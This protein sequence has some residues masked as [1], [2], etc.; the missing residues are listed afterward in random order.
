MTSEAETQHLRQRVDE[1]EAYLASIR[2][3]SIDAV[4]GRDGSL[5]HIA[6][7]WHLNAFF[8]AMNEG[9]V[10][11]SE[12]QRIQDCNPAFGRM[13]GLTQEQTRGMVFA[14][15]M[16]PEEI[17]KLND[18]LAART[19]PRVVV[20][21]LGA[22]TQPVPVRIAASRLPAGAGELHCLFITDMREETAARE[23]LAASELRYRV[24][25]DHSLEWEYWLGADGRC[26]Y[27]SPACEAI[28]GYPPEAFMADAGLV[29]RLVHPDDRP[30][31][32]SHIRELSDGSQ[33]NTHFA[34]EFRLIDKA[35]SEHWVE[36][37]CA[38]IF[39]SDGHC[40]GQRG[41][42]RDI[43]QRKRAELALRESQQQYEALVNRIPDG[44]FVFAFKSDGGMA[45]PYVSPRFC[46]LLG[47]DGP[48]L[49]A[50]AELA[51]AAAHPDD[52]PG[53]RRANE[54]A[55]TTLRPF[56]WEGRFV[57][58]GE[59]RWL[60]VA[61]EA[62]PQPDGG[63]VWN[64]VMSDITESKRAEIQL[65]KLAQAV[66]QSPESVVITDLHAHIEYVN[67]AFLLA[68]GYSREEVYGQN[69]RILH[70][71]KTPPE[72][73]TQMWDTLTGGRPW[74][75]EFVNQRRDGSE[76]TE[77]AIIT[78]VRQPDGKVTHYVAVKEDITEKKRTAEELDQ[79]RHHLE[80]L[81]TERTE[82]LEQ[83]V[84]Q[85]QA[86]TKA[87]AAFL[88]NMSHEIR[89]PMNAILGMTHLLKRGDITPKQAQQLQQVERSSRHLLGLINDI[90]DL[91]KVE[92]GR[93]V[94][95]RL[96]TRV[97]T[98]PAHVQSMLREAADAKGIRIVVETAPLPDGLLGDPTRLTQALLNY[99]SNAV[100]FTQQGR[101]V[102]RTLLVEDNDDN[103]LLRFEVEDS[104]VGVAPEALGRLF[105][106]FEQADNS[107]T[108]RYGGTGL[109][110]AI[111]RR[112]AELMG[113]EW[114]V[115]SVPGEGSTFWFTARL[116]KGETGKGVPDS[117]VSSADAEK[118]IRR[119]RRGARLLLVEDEPVNREVASV[120]LRSVGLVVE[121]AE[122][123]VAALQRLSEGKPFDAVLM[124]MQ[125]PVM[126]GLDATRAVREL[127][128]GSAVPILAM[129]AN[130][131]AEDRE[132][133]L[134]AG[135][136]DF[137]AKPVDPPALFA[138]LLRWLPPRDIFPGVVGDDMAGPTAGAA[139]DKEATAPASLRAIMGPGIDRAQATLR[140]PEQYRR[141]VK[142]FADRQD[143]II[144]QLREALA[145]GDPARA[146]EIT[147]RLKG[148]AGNLGL[149]V[150]F[151][152]AMALNTRLRQDDRAAI[153]PG[154]A[155]LIEASKA[156]RETTSDWHPQSTGAATDDQDPE[157]V[158]AQLN[159]WLASSDARAV[160]YFDTHQAL[161]AR[162]LNADLANLAQQ[163]REFNFS[164]AQSDLQTLQTG[165]RS[166]G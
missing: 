36:H 143:A 29:T 121:E 27:A 66:E 59:T 126:D 25:A 124:D 80:T 157:T 166:S 10:T 33:Q 54:E 40:L 67:E 151:Q 38:P 42:N 127:P 37:V 112:L 50:D 20:R 71:G 83:A 128:D 32:S 21:L 96:P 145:F 74:K 22:D 114:G 41:A 163:I 106:A 30:R 8:Q 56:R 12:D 86:A 78:P 94:L 142:E 101:I 130:A 152:A 95:E 105:S 103:A 102:M 9:A 17:A 154:L 153:E 69:P 98:I 73:Y 88:A 18:L 3:G 97:A 107:T 144:D 65:R 160:E 120:L 162:Y 31:F 5:L 4:V 51:F 131:F 91:S 52:A 55:H 58:Q 76:Y 7:D 89:T 60:R 45:F 63:S 155:A 19:G 35:G 133:C 117:N 6:R 93:L 75:G 115:Q 43:T 16:A 149:D 72:T 92:A 44:I 13:L 53:L 165:G 150:L 49:L 46:E 111:T 135:M 64:G 110:L 81:V 123:G 116:E 2:D 70:S 164:E 28:T 62:T 156:L 119:S 77:F 87:K 99:A 48:A 61:S 57:I 158:L 139:A 134:E 104:G 159:D 140:N 113:G 24:V 148:A 125:M 138:T 90:L 11:L 147:H 132:R 137:I 39:D 100:K 85:A 15:L 146:E 82:Q 84:E 26:I 118:E 141:L 129:T 109:G 34:T 79:H 136:N 47:V 161:L 68:T 1:L 14:S 108:R 23:A 122:N